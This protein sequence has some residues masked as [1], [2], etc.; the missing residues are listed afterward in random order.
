MAKSLGAGQNINIRFTEA[1][2]ERIDA[3]VAQ[4]QAQSPGASFTRSDVVRMAVEAF[5][6]SG[7]AAGGVKKSKAAAG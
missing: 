2:L 7:V 5:T 3:R 1:L 6:S 4:L